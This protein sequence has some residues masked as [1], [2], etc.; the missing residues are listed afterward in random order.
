V[1]VGHRI[2]FSRFFFVSLERL[3]RDKSTAK[4]VW[5]QQYLIS[6]VHQPQLFL[7][8]EQKYHRW[9]FGASYASK[10]VTKG[11]SSNLELLLRRASA[12]SRT[13]NQDGCHKL[14]GKR[15]DCNLFV[16]FLCRIAPLIRTPSRYNV[17]IRCFPR[18]YLQPCY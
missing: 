18:L 13:I 15:K 8:G 17:M 10:N 5:S 7:K 11:P 9:M 12:N 3:G 4:E 2:L 16:L 1:F 14:D 6:N